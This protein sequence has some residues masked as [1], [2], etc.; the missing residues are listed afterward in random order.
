MAYAMVAAARMLAGETDE[1]TG[2]Q[3]PGR[4]PVAPAGQIRARVVDEPLLPGATASTGTAV[5]MA[6]ATARTASAT[7]ATA[8][9]GGSAAP[10]S[11]ALGSTSGLGTSAVRALLLV[12]GTGR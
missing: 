2:H 3:P 12:V 7:A 4:R 9:F 1:E 6:T 5:P 11:A 10:A 8:R